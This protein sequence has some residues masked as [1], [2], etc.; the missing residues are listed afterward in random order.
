MATIQKRGNTYKITVSTGYNANGQQVRQ[1]KTW[2]PQ[3]GMTEK[4]IEKEVNRQS[5]LFEEDC[6]NGQITAAVK[7][8]DFACQWFKEYAEIKLKTQTL[9]NYH[10]AEKRIYKAIGFLRMDK[11]TPRNI[12]KYILDLNQTGLAP[13]TIKNHIC[14]I[15]SIFNYAVKMQ[16]IAFNPCTNVTIPRQEQKDKEIY[17]LEET[18][19]LLDLLSKEDTNDFKFTVFFTLAIF[20]GLRRGELLGLEWQDF[21][22]ENNVVSINRTSN[23]TKE[24]GVYTDTPKTQSSRRS[25]KLPVEIIRFLQNFREHQNTEKELIGDKWEEN[26]R[27]FTQWNGAPMSTNAPCAYFRR[28]CKRTGIRY[29]NIHSWRHFNASVLIFKGV[30]VKSVQ[31]H[32][33]HSSANTT[34]SIYCHEFQAAQAVAMEALTSVISL[35]GL[36]SVNAK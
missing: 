25:I 28:F 7:F 12:Q 16:Q 34:L 1:Y 22:M 9:R 13:K 4:Q 15:S 35:Q 14:L 24:R 29:V 2:K 21:N 26:N 19:N 31:S 5:V 8:E 30:D 32:L 11:I 36:G 17:T 27:L 6:L 33:G 18:Q 3:G 10:F 20:T 23:W